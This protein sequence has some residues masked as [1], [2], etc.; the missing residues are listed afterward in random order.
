SER[1]APPTFDVVVEMV[2]RDEVLVHRDTASAVDRLLAGQ[3]VGGERRRLAD[4]ELQ[5]EEVKSAGVALPMSGAS[6]AERATPRAPSAFAGPAARSGPTR[7][8][9]HA[10]SRDVL[11]RVLRELHV[12]ARV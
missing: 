3:D 8:Y 7:I 5:V 6:S 12:G 10:L 11:E 9:A 2:D 4:G 1:K